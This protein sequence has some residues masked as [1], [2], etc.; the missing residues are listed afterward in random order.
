MYDNTEVF[1]DLSKTARNNAE[2]NLIEKYVRGEKLRYWLT[3]SKE[4]QAVSEQIEYMYCRALDDFNTCDITDK[5]KLEQAKF[6]I[7]VAKRIYGVF[8]GIFQDA[9]M[10]ETLLSED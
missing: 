8:D 9:N 3:N 10:A 6:D 4:G 1:D 5:A 2:L 7:T